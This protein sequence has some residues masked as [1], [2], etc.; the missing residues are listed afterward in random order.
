MVTVNHHLAAE[1]GASVLAQGGNAVDAAVATSLAAGVVEPAMSG[2][3]GRGYMVVVRPEQGIFLAD[4]H[5][6]APLSATPNMFRVEAHGGAG[7]LGWGPLTPVADAA[8]AEGALAVAVPSVLGALE[9]AQRRLGRLA[10]STV[11][12]PAV[13]LAGQG[14]EVGATFA[15]DLERS[16]DKL[17]RFPSTAE[18]FLPG[19]RLPRQGE[20]FVQSDLA[21]SLALISEGG[22]EALASG[23][24]ANAIVTE[25]RRHGGVLSLDDLSLVRPTL[26]PEPLT[27]HFRGFTLVG[28][29]GPTGA[30]TLFQIMNMLEAIGLDD[31]DP[32]STDTCHLLVDVLNTAF[33]DRYEYVDDPAF[34]PVPE[35]A[36][37]GKKYA[38]CRVQSLDCPASEEKS[39]RPDPWAFQDKA[40]AGN[41]GAKRGAGPGADTHTTHLCVVDA[42]GMAVSMTQS[43]I[44]HFGSGLVASGTGILLNS[45]MH[46]FNPVPDQVGSI[47]PWRR[48]AHSGTPLVVT[49][50]SGFPRLC[51]GGAGGT[52]VVTGLAQVLLRVIA[53]DISLQD[54]LSAPRLH[55]ESSHTEVDG[56]APVPVVEELTRHGHSVRVVQSNFAAPYFARINGIYIT[57]AGMQSSGIDPF[58][59]SGA[60]ALNAPVS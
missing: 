57:Q 48:S 58:I 46:N 1:A 60:S 40:A 38:E 39:A 4:G 8:N 23:Q 3:G 21:R 27:V 43:L 44:D 12:S 30:I 47:G 20:I 6:R 35:L 31:G 25:V 51:I 9:E 53:H 11:V 41:E 5:E 19:G 59:D 22:A 32:L 2:L 54:A 7:G 28:L 24:L 18:V 45:A 34:R 42:D 56:R 16:R 36:L 55:S 17:A 26:W 52:R 14:F 15:A 49:D 29:P 33:H 37:A 13:S 10:W 50:G